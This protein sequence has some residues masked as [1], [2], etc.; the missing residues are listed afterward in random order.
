V[1]PVQFISDEELKRSVANAPTSTE[2]PPTLPFLEGAKAVMSAEELTSLSTSSWRQAGPQISKQLLR[3]S[4]LGIGGAPMPDFVLK[5]MTGQWGQQTNEFGQV[6]QWINSS[7]D[8]IKANEDKILAYRNTA[9]GPPDPTLR[10]KEEIQADIK[11]RVAE[12]ETL[13]S[14]ASGLSRFP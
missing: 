1:N 8:F 12:A 14:R 3:M 4:S 9:G 2:F 7:L 5:S 10:T 11:S 13:A 6:D